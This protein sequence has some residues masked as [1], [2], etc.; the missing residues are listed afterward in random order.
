M[1]SRSGGSVGL[2]ARA[3]AG[4]RGRRGAPRAHLAGELRARR[5]GSRDWRCRCRRCRGGAVIGRGA[6]EG[7]AQR[8]IDAAVEIDGLQAGSAPGR[9]T[10]RAPRRS[11]AAPPRGTACRR[12]A[13]RTRR[14][15]RRAARATA[16]AMMSISSRPMRAVLAGMRIEAR[17]PRGAAGRCRN[18][19]RARAA[20]MRPAATISPV[21]RAPRAPPRSGRWTVT[22][23][24]RSSG[25]TSI[26]TGLHA[27]GELAQELG[28]AG[29]REARRRR[30]SP[31]G[32]GW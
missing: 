6:D 20:A 21:R 24:T 25:Q 5:S 22:G 9:D 32:S 2:G 27:A 26:I 28:M 8:D 23:T 10:C 1:T 3:S 18:R 17:R 11:A 16:G 13:G 7:Q 29:M 15:R 30:A 19:A 31:S 14:C 4:E 12:A